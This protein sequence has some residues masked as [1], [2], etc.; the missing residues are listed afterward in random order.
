MVASQGTQQ[1]TG[2]EQEKPQLQQRKTKQK[3][4]K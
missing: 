2:K 3:D 4:Q 1:S